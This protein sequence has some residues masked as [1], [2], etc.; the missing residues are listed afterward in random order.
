MDK[1]KNISIKQ[2]KKKK[3]IVVGVPIVAQWVMTPTSIHGDVGSIPDPVQWVKDSGI[4]VR[5]GVGR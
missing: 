3:L 1:I 5:C 2:K 4:A